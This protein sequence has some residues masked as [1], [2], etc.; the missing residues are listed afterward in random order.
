MEQRGPA[1]DFACQLLSLPCDGIIKSNFASESTAAPNGL[2]PLN[3]VGL[4]VQNNDTFYTQLKVK[5]M[6]VPQFHN[7]KILMDVS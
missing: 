2:S 4:L 6:P 5:C 1:R 3:F 7:C